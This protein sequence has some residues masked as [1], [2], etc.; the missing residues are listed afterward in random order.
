[1]I[2]VITIKD[3]LKESGYGKFLSA[4]DLFQLEREDFQNKTSFEINEE[5]SFYLLI[6]GQMDI[7]YPDKN[8]KNHLL[9]RV[10]SKDYTLGG[11]PK[12]FN[13][14]YNSS[15]I[16]IA[17]LS[18]DALL[19]QIKEK[20]VTEL[21]KDRDFIETTF[22]KYY[23]LSSKIIQENYFRS[24]FTLEEYLAYILYNHSEDDKYTVTNYSLFS[25]LLKCDRTNL[26][27]CLSSL[28]S[29][30][31]IE[32]DGKTIKIL[33]HEGLKYLFDEKL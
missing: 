9:A 5:R 3:Y 17:S 4:D 10:Y 8:G 31:L 6:R 13:K 30:E 22:E 11:L 25:N 21:L 16:Y 18:K 7:F 33:S 1:M 23:K 24:I 12:Y 14:E 27:R 26:Y 2:A 15:H 28:E 29:Q 20:K 32:K 19:Y